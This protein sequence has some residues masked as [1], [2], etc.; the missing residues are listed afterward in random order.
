MTYVPLP[1][2]GQ[3]QLSVPVLDVFCCSFIQTL[4]ISR[5]VC[6]NKAT[7]VWMI[8]FQLKNII[9][10]LSPS[11]VKIGLYFNEKINP[12]HCAM[13]K[14]DP[15]YNNTRLIPTVVVPHQEKHVTGVLLD[16]IEAFIT[17]FYSCKTCPLGFVLFIS[18]FL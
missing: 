3:K 10:E 2:R 7:W 18:F 17:I 14:Q 4:K 15:Q 8:P 9:I 5:S 16:F 12:S 11:C 6:W 1:D 13:H